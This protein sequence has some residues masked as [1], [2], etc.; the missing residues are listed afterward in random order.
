[1]NDPQAE[2]AMKKQTL[3]ILLIL[4]IS[5]WINPVYAFGGK[6][7]KNPANRGM[8]DYKKE[9]FATIKGTVKS[10]QIV[11][12]RQQQENG[13]HLT[14]ATSSKEYIVHVC[15]E[16]YANK[17]NIYFNIGELISISGSTFIKDNLPNI[18][19]ATIQRKSA[20]TLNLRDPDSGQGLWSGRFRDE[21]LPQGHRKLGKGRRGD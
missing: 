8:S 14:I 17:K 16:W 15:P 19:A 18:Y 4:L 7:R 5:A 1:M 12:N 11:F 2:R 9:T 10:S 20:E 3:I 21:N 6:G 13:L